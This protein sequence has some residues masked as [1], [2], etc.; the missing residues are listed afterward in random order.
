ME[1]VRLG[2]FE[3]PVVD[4]ETG[5]LAYTPMLCYF[6]YWARMMYR[7]RIVAPS[8]NRWDVM[9]KDVP[10]PTR[11]EQRYCEIKAHR[12]LRTLEQ[13]GKVVRRKAPDG[14]TILFRARDPEAND[15]PSSWT[16]RK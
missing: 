14:K 5:R 2:Q 11:E 13:V 7:P 8:G 1:A 4:P 16:R 9:F 12:M 15:Y 10:E 3:P 6:G